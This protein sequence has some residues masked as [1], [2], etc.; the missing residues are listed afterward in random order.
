MLTAAPPNKKGRREPP[1][2]TIRDTLDAVYTPLKTAYLSFTHEYSNI[3]ICF[4]AAM[5]QCFL[6]HM[7]IMHS[8][9]QFVDAR[10][11]AKKTHKMIV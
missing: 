9:K 10:L 8:P 4:V 5:T 1:V 3:I 2:T 7:L 6:S 11:S